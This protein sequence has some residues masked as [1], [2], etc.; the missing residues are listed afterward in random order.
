MS[1]LRHIP[2]MITLLR[3]ILI[4]PFIAYLLEGHYLA[5]F[6]IFMIAGLSDGVD[7]ILARRFGWTS[8]FGSFADPLADKLLMISSFFVLA[9]LQVLPIWLVA[10][11]I[12]RDVIIMAGVAAYYYFI[13]KVTFEPSIISKINTVV[14]IMLVFTLLFELTFE[15]LPSVFILSLQALV[16]VL[17]LVSL[18]QY[19]WIWSRHAYLAKQARIKKQSEGS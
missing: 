19:M 17:S 16:L 9:Y 12:A 10:I 2:N 11:I 14:Q 3:I 13:G 5:A 4:W 6:I 8:Y 1:Y 15:T 18:I 7:G